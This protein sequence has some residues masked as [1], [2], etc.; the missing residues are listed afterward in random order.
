MIE[1]EN[2]PYHDAAHYFNGCWCFEWNQYHREVTPWR[3]HFTTE[4]QSGIA[5]SC[6]IFLRRG[7]D[8]REIVTG[9]ELWI[10]DRFITHRFAV[11][12]VEVDDRLYRV[13]FETP[14]RSR[15]KGMTTE[16]I[17]YYNL[18][19]SS[20]GERRHQV[21]ADY[22]SD[23]KIMRGIASVLE[24]GTPPVMARR[25]DRAVAEDRSRTKVNTF[26]RSA[27]RVFVPEFQWAIIKHR[28]YPRWAYVLRSGQHVGYVKRN[29]VN[30]T[31]TFLGI[32][33]TVRDRATRTIINT[34]LMDSARRLL[35]ITADWV[36]R[37]PI[38][39]DNELR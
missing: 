28:T 16:N 32:K 5:H 7:R 6:D 21:T 38:G 20:Q 10:G 19:D 26:M 8:N 30:D 31:V 2:M 39:D 9:Q 15:I 13:S 4:E 29:A 3:M 24:I 11:E 18:I 37:N 14:H 25:M 23:L 34:E 22:P 1:Y 35:S 17:E 33:S 36:D 12:Y 27:R